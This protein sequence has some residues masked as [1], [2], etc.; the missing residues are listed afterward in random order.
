MAN[1]ITVDSSTWDVAYVSTFTTLD[2]FLTAH[3]THDW[4]RPELLTSVYNIVN[5][6]VEPTKGKK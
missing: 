5:K 6:P 3:S 2:S 4:L 1:T